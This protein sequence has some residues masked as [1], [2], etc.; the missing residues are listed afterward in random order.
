MSDRDTASTDPLVAK[1]EDPAVR[2]A[3]IRLAIQCRV[4]P[5]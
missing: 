5:P 1:L 4:M 3:L 2:L